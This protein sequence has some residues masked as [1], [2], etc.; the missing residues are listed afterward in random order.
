MSYILNG[1]KADRESW[2]GQIAERRRHAPTLT[3][4]KTKELCRGRPSTHSSSF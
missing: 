4:E 3:H 2:V 1:E